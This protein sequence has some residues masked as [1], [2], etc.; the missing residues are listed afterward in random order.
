M[1]SIYHV[2]IIELP[3]H[4]FFVGAQFHPEFKSR[5]GKASPL[6]LGK[7]SS[8]PPLELA[9]IGVLFFWKKYKRFSHYRKPLYVG[10][11]DSSSIGSAWS[12]ASTPLRRFQSNR[13]MQLFFQRNSESKSVPERARRKATEG[14]G[15]RALSS[16]RQRRH[17]HLAA[18]RCKAPGCLRF[19][20]YRF[21]LNFFPFLP[22][23]AFFNST[24]PTK[25]KGCLLQRHGEPVPM[26]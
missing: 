6:F 24:S 26:F 8:K 11:I 12:P 9:W 10:R 16:N 23:R 1:Y 14:P 5:P 19:P 20:F 7:T 15:E 4:R 21:C 18:Q 2:Q 3:T 25:E 17:S 22:S 13:Q